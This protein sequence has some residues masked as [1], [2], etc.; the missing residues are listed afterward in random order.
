MSELSNYSWCE[1]YEYLTS[2]SEYFLTYTK[3]LRTVKCST[4]SEQNYMSFGP[5]VCIAHLKL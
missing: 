3:L 4:N 1:C 5:H 2:S